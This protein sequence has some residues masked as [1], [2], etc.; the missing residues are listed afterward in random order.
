MAGLAEAG[1]A[2]ITGELARRLVDLAGDD[3]DPAVDHEARRCMVNVIGTAVGASRHSDVAALVR[4]SAR[5]LGS[6]DV[7][8]PGLD[9]RLGPL[10][11]AEVVGS[12]A[13]LDDFDDT[14][15]ETVIHPG[16]ATLGVLW[17]LDGVAAAAPTS[18]GAAERRRREVVAVAL[19]VEA[20]LRVGMA[21][22]PQHYDAGWH[23]T[24]TCGVVG[25]AVTA[26]LLLGLDAEA[27]GRALGFASGMTVG[28]RE[29]FG[30]F[31]KPLHP[32]K[33]AANGLLAAHL[34]RAGLSAPAAGLEAPGGLLDVLA[35][36]TWEASWVSGT[37]PFD[38]WVLLD[39]SY[40]PFPCG[41]V[42]H[43]AIEAAQRVR[44]DHPELEAAA[45]RAV[46]VHCNP[47]VPEL[48]G[49]PTPT[50]G[51]EG[52]FSA[53]HVVTA[54]LLDGRM[55][56]RQVSDER[57]VEPEL[58]ELRRRVVLAPDDAVGRQAVALTVELED[59]SVLESRVDTVISSRERPLDDAALA[60]KFTDLV[61]PVLGA[62]RSGEL[63][64]VAW[65][66]GRE[67]AIADVVDLAA[68]KGDG[69]TAAGRQP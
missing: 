12:A 16:A 57:V 7:P 5:A 68:G 6:G 3:L 44:A 19:G 1:T 28:H 39:N 14:H 13:H 4:A 32:G 42:A 18:A 38:R 23:I 63:A 49:N 51:L 36:R 53:T 66:W 69:R 20:Q 59:G 48:M 64:A 30:T 31:V 52:R 22:S 8:L 56:L 62:E 67:A 17:S 37:G 65:G 41:V 10:G 26:G 25:A 34:A 55:G 33:A 9:E 54:A 60:G 21:I 24:G 61:E 43:P 58:A 47:L 50:T 46:T 2:G 45:V 15:L 35:R 29:A 40:K 27:L 11:A